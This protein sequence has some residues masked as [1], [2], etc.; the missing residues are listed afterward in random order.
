MLPAPVWY[1]TKIQAALHCICTLLT[2]GIFEEC[3]WFLTVWTVLTDLLVLSDAAMT[4]DLPTLILR[5]SRMLVRVSG[6]TETDLTLELFRR[7]PYPLAV[8][9]SSLS[10]VGC[11][12][13]DTN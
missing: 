8:I 13:L 7:V 4:E 6:H 1:H 12:C 5:V 9:T 3:Q 2:S 10:L 11:H